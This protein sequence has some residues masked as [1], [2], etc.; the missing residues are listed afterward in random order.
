MK[1]KVGD[2]VKGLSNKYGITN[3]NMYLG[4]VKKVGD[5]YIVDPIK[6]YTLKIT[7][8]LSQQKALKKFLETN[9]MKFERVE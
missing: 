4:E 3:T 1:F 2:K 6:T 7:G 5:G 8:T 9:N